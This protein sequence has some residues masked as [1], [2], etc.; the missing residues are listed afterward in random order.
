MD[1]PMRKTNTPQ[2]M[3][4]KSAK[5]PLTRGEF[6]I[7]DSSDYSLVSQYNWHL[8]NTGYAVWRGGKPRHTIRM[9]RLILNTPEGMDTD[10]IN[11]NKLDNRRSNLRVC[12]RSINLHNKTNS[13]YYYYSKKEG[14]WSIDNRYDNWP[15]KRFN[16]EAETV[17]FIEN[18]LSGA[19]YG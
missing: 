15:R 1:I 16:T 19:R 11:H 5:I 2:P 6:A 10:H 13:K 4:G 8:S 3:T 12:S 17:A 14:K 18:I 9:H 7:I